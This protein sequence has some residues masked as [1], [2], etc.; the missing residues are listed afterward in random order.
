MVEVSV[1]FGSVTFVVASAGFGSF[2]LLMTSTGLVGSVVV[3][4]EVFEFLMLT[5]LGVS[6]RGLGSRDASIN[7]R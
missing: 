1:G 3:V 7:P 4:S 2:D 6:M 5:I